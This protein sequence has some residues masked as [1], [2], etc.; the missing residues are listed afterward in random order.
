MIMI[1]PMTDI[2]N[3]IYAIIFKNQSSIKVFRDYDELI[4]SLAYDKEKDTI[5]LSFLE[6]AFGYV[7]YFI[8]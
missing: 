7:S 4:D 8:I 5:K 6:E 3:F 1:K 2:S